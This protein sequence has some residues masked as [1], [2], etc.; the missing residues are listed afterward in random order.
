MEEICGDLNAEHEDLENLVKG[1]DETQ[2]GRAVPFDGWTIKDGISHLAYF[3]RAAYFSAADPE[4]FNKNVEEMVEGFVDFD[5]M[6][7][8]INK[9]GNQ[10]APDRLLVWWRKERTRLLDAYAQLDPKVRLP[11]YGPPMSARSSATARLMET[12]AH[13]Q[14]IADALGIVRIPTDRLRHIA[15]IG[16]ATFSWSFQNRQMDVPETKVRVELNAPSGDQWVWGPKDGE[17]RITGQALDF[18]LAAVKRRHPDDT[19]LNIQGKIASQW[20]GII[21]AFAGPPEQGP[22]PGERIVD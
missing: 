9:E 15:H 1:L 16:V 4:A 22:E 2:W 21:Q 17:D 3:D 5:Q 11:W 18:C 10:M 7:D 12:W 6:H 20:M 14:D 8:K 19:A 13:G